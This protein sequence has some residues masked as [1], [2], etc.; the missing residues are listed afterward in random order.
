MVMTHWRLAW[1]KPRSSSMC[2]RAMFT[3]VPS[4]TIISCAAQMMKS[5]RPSF[6]G[7]V[8]WEVNS[9]D[10]TIT[11]DRGRG[12]RRRHGCSSRRRAG[13]VGRP[14]TGPVSGGLAGAVT[15]AAQAGRTTV[16]T[17]SAM[18]SGPGRFPESNVSWIDMAGR[19]MTRVS[20]SASGPTSPRRRAFSKTARAAY[21]LGS[22]EALVD[23][24]GHLVAH[25]G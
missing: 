20:R 9:S 4:S 5:A 22:D 21:E 23:A 16:S 3:M 24:A 8:S 19:I 11:V 6:L 17:K 12:R 13:A 7:G 10:G 25:G 18:R 14:V 1:L 2:G 15:V